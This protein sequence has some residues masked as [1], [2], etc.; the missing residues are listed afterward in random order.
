VSPEQFAEL[1]VR[2]GP[3]WERR[4]RDRL[5][6]RP[7]RRA[8][9]AGRRYQLAFAARLFLAL[10]HLRHNVPFRALGA[11]V[12]MGKDTAHRAV[13][14]LV[15]L[16]AEVGISAPVTGEGIA[17]VED[18]RQF[19]ERRGPGGGALLDGTFVPTPRPGGG[20]EDQKRQFSGHRR[21]HCRTTQVLTDTDGNPLWVS[22]AEN[23]PTHDLTGAR[24]SGIGDAVAATRTTVIADRG[25]RGWGNR[26]DDP[27]G[28]EVLVPTPGGR[29]G[30]GSYNTEHARL[31][32][33]AEHGIRRL[34]RFLVL[35]HDRR[36]DDH[37]TD[38]LRAVAAVATLRP[39]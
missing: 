29:R 11:L 9:G 16:L 34:K 19:F 24:R 22:E 15:P 13:S 23:G 12:G 38:T 36:H 37:L 10:L 8:L 21:R 39:T 14:E 35:H 28:L 27:E 6:D 31:R 26:A 7:R 5:E 3:V 2:V 20:W 25:Y 17:S 32:V 33:K 1:V 18:L 30:H 4:R